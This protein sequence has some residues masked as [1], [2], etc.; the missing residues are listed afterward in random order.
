[1]NLEQLAQKIQKTKEQT[2]RTQAMTIDDFIKIKPLLDA[3][4]A[5]TVIPEN[6][7]YWLDREMGGIACEIVCHSQDDQFWFNLAFAGKFD[8]IQMR[9]A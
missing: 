7:Q 2:S 5:Y 3:T 9:V 8:P 4:I 6:Y 1:M